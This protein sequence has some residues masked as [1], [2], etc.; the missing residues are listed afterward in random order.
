MSEFLVVAGM[1]GA[2]RSTAAASLDDIGWFVIDGLPPA[3]ITELDQALR[4]H[5]GL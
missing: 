1:S 5:L 2:G 4:I 3:L